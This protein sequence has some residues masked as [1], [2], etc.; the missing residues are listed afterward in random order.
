MPSD[1][2][3]KSISISLLIDNQVPVLFTLLLSSRKLK[4]QTD[5]NEKLLYSFHTA[6]ISINMLSLR[7]VCP[8]VSVVKQACCVCRETLRSVLC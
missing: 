2:E 8:L 3:I 5:T 6:A 4:I 7:Q 1:E